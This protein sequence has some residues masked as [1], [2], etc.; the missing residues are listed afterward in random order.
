MKFKS[1]LPAFLLLFSI[2]QTASGQ[3]EA[4]SKLFLEYKETPGE[5]NVVP[6]DAIYMLNSYIEGYT[7]LQVVDSK[8]ESEFTF[9]LYIYKKALGDRKGRIEVYD[10]KSGSLLF[11]TREWRGTMNA[12][13][14][15]SGSRHAIGLSFKKDILKEYPHIE[16]NK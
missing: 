7:H 4:A 2:C 5:K 14:G 16:K 6:E 9:V 11:Q 3:L 13:Y 8:E 15:Y 10:S 12:F 1:L